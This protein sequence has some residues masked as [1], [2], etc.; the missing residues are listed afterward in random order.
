VAHSVQLAA[1][2]DWFV[3][4]RIFSS[5]VAVQAFFVLSGL[6]VFGSYSRSPSIG[7]FYFRR[8]LRIYPAYAVGVLIF[9]GLVLGT[10]WLRGRSLAFGELPRYLAANLSLLNFIQPGIG[11]AF[12]T[13]PLSEING[14]LWTI[15]VEVGFYLL[16]PLLWWVGMRVSTPMLVLVM[17][18]IGIG[19]RPL[20]DMLVGG[21]IPVHRSLAHQLPGQLHFFAVGVMLYDCLTTKRFRLPYVA[22][23]VLIPMVAAL[24]MQW[25]ACTIMLLTAA[26]V[27]L[28]VRLPSAPWRMR[29]DLSYG[30]YLAHFPILQMLVSWHDWR[31]ASGL[32]IIPIGLLGAGAYAMLSWHFLERP[33][34]EYMKIKKP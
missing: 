28:A 16:V 12:A 18:V 29:V 9:A 15:K 34:I 26:I 17:G 2:D 23:L 22:F 32:A 13:N 31:G 5:E 8:F 33:A 20:I 27:L 30:I 3:L 21:G 19:W 1:L 4:R 7:D 25:R 6:L 14:A 24:S 11:G 10:E